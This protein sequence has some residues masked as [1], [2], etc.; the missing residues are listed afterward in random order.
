MSLL[1]SVS[2]YVCYLWFHCAFSLSRSSVFSFIN[3]NFGMFNFFVNKFEFI[4]LLEVKIVSRSSGKLTNQWVGE[5]HKEICSD[6]HSSP[7]TTHNILKVGYYC[8]T[9]SRCAQN[10]GLLLPLSA[11][12]RKLQAS[13]FSCH[14]RVGGLQNLNKWTR[15]IHLYENLIFC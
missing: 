6:H 13:I 12:H 7:T 10:F 11:H 4:N 3:Y 15:I 2:L 9:I 5:I 14:E 8:P 1:N